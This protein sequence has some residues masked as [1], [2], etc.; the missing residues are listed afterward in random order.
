MFSWLE[1]ECDK[2]SDFSLSFDWDYVEFGYDLKFHGQ[3]LY[4]IEIVDDEKPNN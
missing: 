2:F 4:D 3:I 1:C